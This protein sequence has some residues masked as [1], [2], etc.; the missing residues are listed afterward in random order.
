MTN[1]I[2]QNGHVILKPYEEGEQMAGNILL[3]DLGKE[4]PEMGIV[5]ESCDTYNWNT[6]EYY[7]TKLQPGDKVLIPKMGTQRVTVGMEEYFITKESEII[8]KIID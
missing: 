2:P 1:L 4:K 8:A 3:P 5:V 7:K 6:G